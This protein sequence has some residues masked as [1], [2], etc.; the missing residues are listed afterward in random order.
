MNRYG[1]LTH[2]PVDRD[3]ERL[4]RELSVELP[5]P[6]ATAPDTSAGKAPTARLRSALAALLHPRPTSVLR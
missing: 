2:G 5:D 6:S 3:R 4:L 1:T